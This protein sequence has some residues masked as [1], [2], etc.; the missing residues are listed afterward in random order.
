MGIMACLAGNASRA[1]QVAL[2]PQ[3]GHR[4]RLIH[5]GSTDHGK[6]GMTGADRQVRQGILSRTVT[7]STVMPTVIL[8]GC[9]SPGPDAGRRDCRMNFVTHAARAG[10]IRSL[11]PPVL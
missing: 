1:R 4:A 2:R 3:C 9:W 8:G 5:A 7:P 11:F 6:I 10:L